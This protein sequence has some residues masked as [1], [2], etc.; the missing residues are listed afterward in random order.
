MLLTMTDINEMKRLLPQ[1]DL[2][3]ETAYPQEQT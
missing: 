2:H 3:N 1:F